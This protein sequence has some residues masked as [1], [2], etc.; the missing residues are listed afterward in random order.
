MHGKIVYLS[1]V[2]RASFLG[3]CQAQVKSCAVLSTFDG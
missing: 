3:S 1:I 2:W